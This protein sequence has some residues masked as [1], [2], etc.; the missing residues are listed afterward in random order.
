MTDLEL[1]AIKISKSE[2]QGVTKKV[3]FFH[4]A[5]CIWRKIQMSRLPAQ[6]GK[7]E[8]VSL[9]MSYLPVLAFLPADDIPGL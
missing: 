5:Q 6:H 4:S 1:G 3:C 7:N 8:N 2:F 9:K